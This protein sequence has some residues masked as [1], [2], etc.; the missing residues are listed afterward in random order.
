M[1]AFACNTYSYMR[2][3]TAEEC[4]DHLA[5]LGFRDFELMMHPGHAWPNDM[6]A[7]A[8]AAL[9]GAIE[10]RGLRL[11]SLNMPNID[12]N[13]AAASPEMRDYT[14]RILDGI[15]RLAGEL[16]VPGVV[17]VPGKHNPLFPDDAEN[18]AARFFA[19]LDRLAPLAER[20]GTALWIENVPFAFEGSTQGLMDLLTR[21]GDDAIG[22]CFD[23][24]NAHFIGED[25]PAALACCAPRLKIVHLS[26]TNRQVYRH[27]PVGQGDVPFGAI[28][29]A[30]TAVGHREPP[31]LEVISRDP[32]RDIIASQQRLI[33][34]GFPAHARAMH[35]G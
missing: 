33:A 30:L 35:Q 16:G 24:A 11:V 27:D 18:L 23:A 17:M 14:L 12:L 29:A 8:R 32:D 34:L 13:V 15:V 6:N 19:A 4:L 2:S 9:R 10:A 21:Y 25:I 1:T 7:A 31:V 22:I 26:D 20:A 5:E 3:H 28:P